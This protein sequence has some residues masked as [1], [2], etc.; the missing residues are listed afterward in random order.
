ME[1]TVQI[2]DELAVSLASEGNLSSRI[3]EALLAEEYRSGRL[4]KP[5]L[6]KAIGAE[7]SYEL[8]RLSQAA[9]Y[10]D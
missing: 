1:V 7:T 10:L 2:P 3:V 8:D 6:R 4:T 9:S 5:Q